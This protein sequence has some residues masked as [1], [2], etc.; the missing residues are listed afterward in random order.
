M[1]R[2]SENFFNFAA[3]IALINVYGF[4]LSAVFS[5]YAGEFV[6]E[7]VLCVGVVVIH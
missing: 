3:L 7:S 2:Y 1:H 6:Y 4:N 5:I